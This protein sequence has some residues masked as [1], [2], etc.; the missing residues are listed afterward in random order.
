MWTNHVKALFYCL[1]PKIISLWSNLL[2]P[3]VIIIYTLRCCILNATAFV[4]LP[5]ETLIFLVTSALCWKLDW[6]DKFPLKF[7]LFFKKNGLWEETD[8]WDG[9]TDIS[10]HLLVWVCVQQDMMSKTILFGFALHVLISNL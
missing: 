7:A 8:R 3:N 6:W 10:I 4:W 2:V 9:R 5:Q 1:F